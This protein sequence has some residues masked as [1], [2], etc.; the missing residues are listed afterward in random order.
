M[1]DHL[2]SDLLYAAQ[3]ALDAL[4]RGPIYGHDTAALLLKTAVQ[5]LALVELQT[6]LDTA[7]AELHEANERANEAEA[8]VAA[9]QADIERSESEYWG[10]HQT[11]RDLQAS[12]SAALEQAPP[13]I[14]QTLE[15]LVQAIGVGETQGDGFTSGTW[16]AFFEAQNAI[17]NYKARRKSSDDEAMRLLPRREPVQ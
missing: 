12:N 4:E 10:L 2:S 15:R 8:Q 7:Y 6:A 1:T 3:R 9:V 16:T 14:V 13:A 5:A 11:I 17:A